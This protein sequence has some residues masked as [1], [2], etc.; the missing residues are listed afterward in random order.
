VTGALRHHDFV[1]YFTAASTTPL[2]CAP[3]WADRD[4]DAVVLC[5]LRR[6]RREPVGARRDDR[7]HPVG[8]PHA[9]R[10]AQRDEHAVHRFGEMPEGHLL[11]EDAP[12]APGVRQRAKQHEHRLTPRGVVQLKPIPLDLLAGRVVDLDRH[13]VA[14][15]VLADQADRPQLQPA[16]L[17]DQR[18]VG[19]VEPGPWLAVQH[20]RVEVRIIDEPRLDVAAKRLQATRRRRP[21]L[22]SALAALQVLAHRLRVAAGVPGDL[23]HL[24]AARLQRV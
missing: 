19:P 23:R 9:R 14:A 10:A 1:V 15:V 22:A 17:T 18:R 24:P 13:R 3:R 5:R 7:G 4:L 6:V 21:M 20:G 2:R 8:P 11:A 12:E 16:Q